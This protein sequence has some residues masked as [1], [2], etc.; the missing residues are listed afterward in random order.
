MFK[1]DEDVP[2]TDE[3]VWIDWNGSKF[4]IAHTSN[5]KFQRALARLQ[6]PYKRK[7]DA[8]TMD[9][10]KNRQI[11]AQAMS[12]ALL[13]DWQNVANKE[14]DV[15]PYSVDNGHKALIK[16]E[17]FRDFVSNFA[18]NL[19]NFRSEVVEEMGNDSSIG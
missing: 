7:L 8:G 14:G 10:A 6:Q 17:D 1:F 11:L 12:E 3:G 5:M 18:M 15:T 9:P 2:L 13:L 16:S 19:D 4:K